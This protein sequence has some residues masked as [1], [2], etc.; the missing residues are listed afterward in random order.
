MSSVSLLM[1]TGRF[2]ERFMFQMNKTEVEM[3]YPHLSKSQPNDTLENKGLY[4]ILFL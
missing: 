3:E 2:P 4:E 1:V